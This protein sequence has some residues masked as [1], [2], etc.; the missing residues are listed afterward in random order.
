VS[1]NR[2][3]DAV[4]GNRG[5]DSLFGGWGADYVFG[6]WGPDQLHALAPDGQ[7]DLLDCGLGRDRAYVLRSERR[8]TVLVSCER[9]YLVDVLNADQQEGELAEAD[10][11]AGG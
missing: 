1:G 3:D 8:L 10:V 2:G 11:E 4:W 6:G 7:R 5:R 9:V